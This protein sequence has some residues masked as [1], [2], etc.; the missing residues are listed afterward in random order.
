MELFYLERTDPGLDSVE[1]RGAEARHIARVLRHR[2]GDRI[3]ATDG[4]GTELELELKTVAPD[5]VAGL[6][7]SRR[8]RPRE[9][10]CLLT[11]AQ[12]VLKGNGL[13][14]VVEGATQVGVAG[15][16]LLNTQ[17][18]VGRVSDRKRSRLGKVA[19]EAM[20]VST[21]TVAP[22]V[23]GPISIGELEGRIAEYELALIAYE[24]EK[25]TGLDGFLYRTP[26]SVLVIVGPEG[27]F[28][29]AE[30]VRLR[31]AGAR[32]FSMGPRRLRADTAGIV[33][34]AMLLQMTGD[35]GPDRRNML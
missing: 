27:G 18:T 33:A 15:I 3:W 6:V 10:R 7:K 22:V 20:K 23:S 30:V 35:L 1:F 11:L 17:R 12:G 28:E 13:S 16:I 24:E 31:Q 4:L 2:V 14:R 21:R 29:P 32:P 34:S 19:V 26:S 5:R 25:K 8:T 9:P